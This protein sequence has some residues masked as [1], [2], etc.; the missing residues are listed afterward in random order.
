VF[1]DSPGGRRL[2]HSKKV[3]IDGPAGRL[4]GALRLAR[5]AHA[6]A[7]VAH[8]HPLHGGTLHNPVVFHADRELSRAGFTTFRFNFRGVGES[9]GGHDDG[10]GEVDDLGA[11]VGHVRGIAGDLPLILVGYSFGAVCSFRYAERDPKVA[12]VIAIGLPVRIYD[13]D[14]ALRF[15]RPIAVIQ[16]SK[17]ELG[18]PGE[19]R[20]RLRNTQPAPDIRIVDGA[21]HM[22]EGQAAAIAGTIVETA[23]SILR[24]QQP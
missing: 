13:V 3:W 5:P 8:P 4:E 9:E 7:V 6:A 16:G 1:E 18:L 2:G 11:A 14:E 17:D 23:K 12:A 20:D 22:F 15:N 19:V 21:G 24:G 10:N